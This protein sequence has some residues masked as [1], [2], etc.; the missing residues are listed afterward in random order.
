MADQRFFL[1]DIN[2]Q[3]GSVNFPRDIAHQIMHVLRLQPGDQ[4]TVLDGEGRAYQVRLNLFGA[5][6]LTATI[7]QVGEKEI[8]LPVHLTLFFPLTKREK[9][10]WILQK[11]TEVGVSVFRP[12]I[13]DRSLVKTTILQPN[14][15]Q[16]W[17]AI[18]REAAEQSGRAF[19]P[20]LSQ[21]QALSHI[22]SSAID[23]YG[24][25]AALVAAVG[26]STGSLGP[27]LDLLLKNIQAKPA[28]GLL[29]G[30]EGGF[31]D[32]ELALFRTAKFDLVSLGQTILRMETAAIVFPALVLHHF[33]D[34][35]HSK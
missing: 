6:Q 1:Q 13:S 2:P 5:E 20:E 23:Q 12:F 11:G 27:L 33:F 24:L 10:E 35:F 8:E 19:L 30:A 16:R 28:L 15:I 25:D 18:I 21:P 31:S 9:V 34:R 4:V 17:E 26:E 3:S 22:V 14:K 7:D 29:I 32:Q